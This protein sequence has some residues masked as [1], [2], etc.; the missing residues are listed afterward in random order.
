[1]V[2]YTNYTI[3]QLNADDE[4]SLKGVFGLWR[5]PDKI[6]I[7]LYPKWMMRLKRKYASI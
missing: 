1:M 3:G 7:R 5:L 6:R 4:I 2:I